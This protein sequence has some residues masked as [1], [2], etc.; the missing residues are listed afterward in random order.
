M[1]R[2][3]LIFCFILHLAFSSS[4]Q[5]SQI[6]S[7]NKVIAQN[8]DE[9]EVMRAYNNLA[10]EYS[11]TDL[12]KARTL[13]AQAIVIGRK[14]NHHRRL[15]GS[16]AQLVYLLQDLGKAD[17]AEYYLSLIK[18]LADHA[19]SSDKDM[20]ST[21]YYSTSALYYK[22]LGNYQK[23]IPAFERAIASYE[24]LGDKESIAGQSL[25]LGNT[26]VALGNF[27]KATELHLKALRI[28]EELQSDRGMSFCYQSLCTSFMHLKQYDK[29]LSFANK[30]IKIK[31][32]LG[33]Q[34]GLGTAQS[35]LGDI[36]F[37]KGDLD[38]AL[39]H[40]TA[41]LK[42][43][44]DLKNIGEEYGNYF[45]IGKVYAARNEGAKAIEYFSISKDLA[46]RM[47]D[48]SAL[49]SIDA[50]MI[51]LQ[52]GK[53]YDSLSENKLIA[54]LQLFQ[55]RG[56]LNRQADNYKNMIDF[57]TKTRQFE[58]AL[59]YNSLYYKITDSIRNNEL[60]LQTAKMAEQYNLEKK[61]Q[62]IAI[63][64]KDQQLSETSLQK[65]KIIQYTIIGLIPLL[66]LVGFLVVNRIKLRGKMKQLELRNQIAADLHDEVGS[67]LSSIHLLSQMATQQGSEASHKDLLT[68]MSNNAKET[69]DK[70]GDIV[71]M[72]KHTDAEGTSLKQ[73]MERFAYELCGSKNIEV[74]LQLES[75]ASAELSME[76]R[77]GIYLVFKEAVNNAVKYSGAQRI[78]V[79]TKEEGSNL[80]LK[81]QDS[82]KGF[83]INKI[84]KGN[85]LENMNNR[86]RELEGNLLVT[87]EL[88]GGTTIQ[89][90]V[91]A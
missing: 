53:K 39:Q 73:R 47:H 74:V 35:G 76:Q 24:K 64:K 5:Q 22:K 1:H 38:R 3:L 31:T 59:E 58:K 42:I 40:F 27:Q 79:E 90:T 8:K 20:I 12:A 65:Q 72:I 60:Q 67:S 91:P 34:R 52:S 57:Y 21:I 75:L 68:R 54:S 41:A 13:L 49:A 83:D 56:D 16:Y 30:S 11:R 63:L 26:Y 7:L 15:S 19:E 33:D 85:G 44:K 51:A 89:L 48:S 70:M 81:I 23:S 29:A 80:V 69:M 71:W 2:L 61:E 10:F 28:F 86:A 50:E 43:S 87:S 36:Y 62:E 9:A 66:I 6:D 18:E 25:N 46:G 77:K 32:E 78:W 82:G 17:S 88:A 84:I 14:I 37:G 4:A 55:Q 45:N